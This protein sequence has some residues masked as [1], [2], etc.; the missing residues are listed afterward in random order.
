MRKQFRIIFSMI[1]LFAG[2][3]LTEGNEDLASAVNA[4][5]DGI[6]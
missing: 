2:E 3:R 6:R 4:A 5:T 1:N